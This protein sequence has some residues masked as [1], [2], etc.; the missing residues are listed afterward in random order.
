MVSG[1]EHSAYSWDVL[2]DGVVRRSEINMIVCSGLPAGGH[3][4][5]VTMD[6]TKFSAS[7]DY[8]VFEEEKHSFNRDHLWLAVAF[9]LMAA[10]AAG[11]IIRRRNNIP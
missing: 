6:G 7:F 4:I 11:V 2:G 10:G 1:P 9:G 8:F 3:T 5:T